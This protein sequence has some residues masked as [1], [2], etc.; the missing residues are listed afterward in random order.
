MGNT[1]TNFIDDITGVTRRK[2][3]QRDGKY[4]STAS[5]VLNLKGDSQTE[6][7][8]QADLDRVTRRSEHMFYKTA[9]SEAKTAVN[10]L[11]I[12]DRNKRHMYKE[13]PTIF[14]SQLTNDADSRTAKMRKRKLEE[15]DMGGNKRMKDAEVA[16]LVPHNFACASLYHELVGCMTGIQFDRNIGVKHNRANMASFLGQKVYLDTWPSLLVVPIMTVDNVVSYQG[17]RY[18]AIVLAS[19]PSVYVRCGFVHDMPCATY[20]EIETAVQSLAQFVKAVACVIVNS[21]SSL[22]ENLHPRERQ[23]V[24]NGIESVGANGLKIPTLSVNEM[25]VVAG[26]IKVGK[27]ALD[28]HDDDAHQECD[29]FALF[30]KAVAVESYIQDQK[31]LPGCPMVHDC[32]VCLEEGWM[33]CMCA[34]YDP[35]DQ[36]PTEIVVHALSPSVDKEQNTNN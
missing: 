24:K 5:L 27:V 36:I 1:I 17:G 8:S 3:Q 28:M 25:D 13:G 14:S 15:V 20:N 12:D 6:T 30:L 7:F 21:D 33:Q 9:I 31:I 16:H 19:D 32:E 23:L 22:I 11:E 26:R 18:E 10:N 35:E 2:L 34:A 4:Y 29:P